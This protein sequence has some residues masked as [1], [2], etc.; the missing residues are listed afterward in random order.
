MPASLFSIFF[1]NFKSLFFFS[2]RMLDLNY[3]RHIYFLFKNVC[4]AVVS[5]VGLG[6][7][8]TSLFLIYAGKTRTFTRSN[9]CY[10][11]KRKISSPF[12]VL[13]QRELAT[14]NAIIIFTRYLYLYILTCVLFQCSVS[15]LIETFDYCLGCC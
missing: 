11:T 3:E 6:L 13:G 2:L 15:R 7:E 10:L 14:R 8:S 4:L 5:G 12:V 9:V 1:L